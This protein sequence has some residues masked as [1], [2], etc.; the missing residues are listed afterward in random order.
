M[1]DDQLS[2][3]HSELPAENAG[4]DFKPFNA[5]QGARKALEILLPMWDPEGAP[6]QELSSRYRL[7]VRETVGLL[8]GIASGAIT[9]SQPKLATNL[10]R[11]IEE[12]ERVNGENH[13]CQELGLV[14]EIAASAGLT[15]EQGGVTLI[16]NKKSIVR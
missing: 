5:R 14:M 9:V 3:S 15:L 8:E 10:E 11:I 12:V 4:S 6:L 16:A 2:Y 7:I 1:K 13:G